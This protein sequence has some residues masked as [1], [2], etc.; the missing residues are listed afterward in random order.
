MSGSMPTEAAL[1]F[2]GRATFE[3]LSGQSGAHRRVHRRA[4]VAH[5]RPARQAD[6]VVIAPATADLLARAAAGR[7]D[8]L[9]T[10]TLLATR[11]P[12]LM[13]PAMHTEMWNHPATRANVA[14]RCAAAARSSLDPAVGPAH[15]RR[16]G[17]GRLPEPEHIAALA[18]LLLGAPD[19]LPRDLA[20][21]RVLVTAGG[22]REPLDPVR[23][24][25]NRVLR[26]AGLRHRALA[27]ARGAE[28]TL[29][30]ANT[31]GL[32]A[33]PGVELRARHHRRAAGS[34][35]RPARGRTWTRW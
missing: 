33:P 18:E 9:L 13:A 10:A 31:I 16:S 5:V 14:R 32:A 15:R 4:R 29:V 35:A 19:A 23:F 26:Q 12:V 27:A 17:P 1:Q 28:V 2:V 8:D 7:A 20:G 11:A 21:R 34:G 22:T 3:A 6:L 25:G 24:L 30:A